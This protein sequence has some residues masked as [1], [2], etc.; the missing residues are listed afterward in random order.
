MQL[1]GSLISHDILVDVFAGKGVTKI[2]LQVVA[3]KP[4]WGKLP[5]TRD[6]SNNTTSLRASGFKTVLYAPVQSFCCCCMV[7]FP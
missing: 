7:Y 6:I 2:V 5:P 3:A 1:S 4:G